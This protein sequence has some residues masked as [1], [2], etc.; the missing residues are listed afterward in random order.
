M[1]YKMFIIS[2]YEKYFIYLKKGVNNGKLTI[3]KFY[4]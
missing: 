3:C 2:F 1:N 4:G